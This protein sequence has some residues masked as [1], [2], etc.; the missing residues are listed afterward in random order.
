LFAA[1]ADAALC[2]LSFAPS[3]IGLRQAGI[4]FSSSS[5][6]FFVAGVTEFQAWPG[7]IAASDTD[8]F[9]SLLE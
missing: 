8:H 9:S 5:P 7:G 2:L 3:V 4:P 1:L 6:Q